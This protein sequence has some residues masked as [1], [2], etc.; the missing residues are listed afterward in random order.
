MFITAVPITNITDLSR[1]GCLG[2]EINLFCQ[3]AGSRDATTT[4]LISLPPLK[5]SASMLVR[6]DGDNDEDTARPSIDTCGWDPGRDPG[7]A[8]CLNGD[9]VEDGLSEY[10]TDFACLDYDVD[11]SNFEDDTYTDFAGGRSG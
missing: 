6:Q 9:G 11:G 10:E 5:P 2:G 1:P 4:V 3:G 8:L 7:R